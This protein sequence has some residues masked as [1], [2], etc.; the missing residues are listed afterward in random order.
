MERLEQQA[1]AIN[2]RWQ[3]MQT[4]MGE[5]TGTVAALRRA[6]S[7]NAMGTND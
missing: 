2:E 3:S 5:L 4:K 6:S 7:P 1:Q